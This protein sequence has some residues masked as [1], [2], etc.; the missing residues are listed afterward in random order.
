MHDPGWQLAQ[1]VTQNDAQKGSTRG[2]QIA[3]SLSMSDSPMLTKRMI[4]LVARFHG[5]YHRGLVAQSWLPLSQGEN[6]LC[7]QAEVQTFARGCF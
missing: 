6:F 7:E 3:S 4:E 5:Q 1:D 2:V